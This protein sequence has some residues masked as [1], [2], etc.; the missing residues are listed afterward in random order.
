MT[1]FPATSGPWVA[2]AWGVRTGDAK[3]D[4]DIAHCV[5]AAHEANARLIAAAPCMLAALREAEEALDTLDPRGGNLVHPSKEKIVD[6]AMA[7]IRAAI[8]KAV[9]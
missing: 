2:N 4:Y 9:A 6:E 7:V 3:D 5:G 8:A 1:L